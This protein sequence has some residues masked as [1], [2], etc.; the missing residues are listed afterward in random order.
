MVIMRG[1]NEVAG[2]MRGGHIHIAE[3]RRLRN[4]VISSR[5]GHARQ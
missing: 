3:N 4:I 2:L 1:N 5:A